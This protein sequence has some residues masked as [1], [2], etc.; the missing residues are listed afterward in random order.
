MAP[1]TGTS[2]D[3][4]ISD[5][6][7]NHTTLLGLGGNDWL[8]GLDGNDYLFGGDGNDELF[9]GSG[10]DY[11]SGGY[12]NDTVSYTSAT[13]GV[14]LQLGQSAM[15]LGWVGLPTGRAV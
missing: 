8:D 1:I 11:L 9:G 5:W 3:D 4:R 13:T 14:Y 12:D 15:G 2:G 6:T 10:N 7:G